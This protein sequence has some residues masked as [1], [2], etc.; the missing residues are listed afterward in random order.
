MS[1]DD[2]SFR[3]K[4]AG[5][6]TTQESSIPKNFELIVNFQCDRKLAYL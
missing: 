4:G 1:P 6:D 3:V 5:A 2:P